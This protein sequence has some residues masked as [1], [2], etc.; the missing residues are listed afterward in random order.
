[1]PKA[2]RKSSE[3]AEEFGL[4]GVINPEEAKDHTRDLEAL[5]M[6]I[7]ERV[8]VGDTEN[9]LRETLENMKTRLAATFPALDATDINSVFQAIK[10]K[11]FK[12]LLPRTEEVEN[13]LEEL[14]PSNEMPPALEVVQAV[15]GEDVI[16]ETDKGL[17]AEL[18]DALEIAHDQLATACS[19]LGRLSHTLKP[20]Q[21]SLLLRASIRPLIQL[22]MAARLELDTTTQRPQNYPK[23]RQRESKC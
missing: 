3:E 21:L 16:T 2:P 9:L 10:D 18:F 7:K 14:L 4:S 17:I 15:Q 13:L 19:L 23:N 8:K 12:V 6:N 1:M 11:E 20:G 22:R 5:M